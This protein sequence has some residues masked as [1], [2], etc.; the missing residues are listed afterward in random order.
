MG[1]SGRPG[2]NPAAPRRLVETK[3]AVAP[4][5]ERLDVPRVLLENAVQ[6][7]DRFLVAT[8]L[9]KL[10]A[11]I[12]RPCGPVRQRR[13]CCKQGQQ[14]RQANFKRNECQ[15][16]DP[17]LAVSD[18]PALLSL[19]SSLNPTWSRTFGADRRHR[20]RDMLRILV[21]GK[22]PWLRLATTRYPRLSGIP[23]GSGREGR[24]RPHRTIGRRP[25]RCGARFESSG[26]SPRWSCPWQRTRHRGPWRHVR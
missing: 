20:R 3:I 4:L 5:D 2:R 21:A 17:V 14:N 11:L 7:T 18:S 24:P 12:S 22:S 6:R 25:G 10:E 23:R 8:G 16:H 9:V 19:L 1:C 13:R 26:C 15:P